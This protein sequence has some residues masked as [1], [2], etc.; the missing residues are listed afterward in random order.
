MA[1][2]AFKSAKSLITD[3]IIKKKDDETII[4]TVKAAFPK[5]KV[6]SKHCTKYRR[7]LF[8]ALEI[9]AELA[10]V[11]STDHQEWAHANMAAAK[12]GPH[13]E[14]W[15]QYAIDQKMKAAAEKAAAKATKKS[16]AKGRKKGVAATAEAAA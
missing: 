10:A 5:S 7:E 15:K 3:L 12:R 9:T 2:T 11:G 8:T 4:E 1:K 13:K 14:Y 6:D 16:P